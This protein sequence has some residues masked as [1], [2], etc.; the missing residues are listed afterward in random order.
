MKLSAPLITALLGIFAAPQAFAHK[1]LHHESPTSSGPIHVEKEK[2][3]ALK[4]VAT[5]YNKIVQPI[6]AN[7]CMDCHSA[8]TKY[9]WYYKIPG[10]MQAIDS[11]IKEAREHLDLTQGFPFKSHA[12]PEEDLT[13][14]NDTIQDGSMPPFSYRMFHRDSALTDPERK[15]VFDWIEQAKAALKN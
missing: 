4:S 1:G 2:E 15:A 14:I 3:A 12:S 8:Q 7:K 5:S 10:V 9:P 6:F 11:D 13:A